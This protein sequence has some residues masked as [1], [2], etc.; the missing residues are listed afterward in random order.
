MITFNNIP[1]TIR[2][3]GVLAEIDDSMALT[4]LTASPHKL[5]II[6]QKNVYTDNRNLV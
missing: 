1:N 5:L 4:G 3:P 6:G 2:T